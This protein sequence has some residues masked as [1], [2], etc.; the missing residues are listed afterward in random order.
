MISCPVFKKND[1][2]LHLFTECESA[3]LESES[4]IYGVIPRVQISYVCHKHFLPGD[5]IQES[6]AVWSVRYLVNII[7]IQYEMFVLNFALY[8]VIEIEC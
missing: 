7:E 8:T 2:K 5:T 1:K 3:Q 6:D 4:S